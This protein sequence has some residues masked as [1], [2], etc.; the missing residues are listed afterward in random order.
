M[1][2]S[3][4]QWKTWNSRFSD[5]IAGSNKLGYVVIV[6][7]YRLYRAHRLAWLYMTG[8][9]PPEE[10]DH[11]NHVKNDNRWVNLQLADRITNNRN[12]SRRKDNKSGV[13][14]VNWHSTNERWVVYISEGGRIRHLGS[15]T[16]INVARVVRKQAEKDMGY[17]ENHGVRL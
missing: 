12:A 17:H 8:E 4:R 13:T 3:E 11:V 7:N 15:F 2:K 9:W 1:F 14:G 10:I 5:K 6:F 16:D